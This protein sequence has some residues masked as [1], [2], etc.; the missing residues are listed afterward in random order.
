MSEPKD[1]KFAGPPLPRPR[2]T[3]VVL[4]YGAYGAALVLAYLVAGFAGYSYETQERAFVPASVRQ[5]PGGYRSYHLWHSGYQ[6]G[7]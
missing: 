5:A 4:A 2:W 6:G 3:W 1:P 7:K